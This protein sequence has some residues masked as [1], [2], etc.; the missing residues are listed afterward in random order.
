MTNVI[1][2]AS[3]RAA[4]SVQ[5]PAQIP[6]FKPVQPNPGQSSASVERQQAIESA[7]YAA[8]VF[9]RMPGTASLHAATG[10]AS[11]ALSLLK[12]ACTEAQNGGAA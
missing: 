1:S 10:R 2:L 9:I 3:H 5:A 6:D 7:L 12:N 11:R 8:L 4:I